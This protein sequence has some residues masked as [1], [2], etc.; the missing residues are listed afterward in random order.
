[1]YIKQNEFIK[2]K[3]EYLI[4]KKNIYLHIRIDTIMFIGTIKA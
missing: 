1:M 4:K 2:N 3:L